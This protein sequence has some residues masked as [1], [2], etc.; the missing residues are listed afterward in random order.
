MAIEDPSEVIQDSFDAQNYGSKIKQEYIVMDTPCSKDLP[1]NCKPIP[2]DSAVD[3]TTEDG[4][5]SGDTEDPDTAEEPEN[6]EDPEA[7]D[8]DTENDEDP[9]AGDDEAQDSDVDS[10][11]FESENHGHKKQ[12]HTKC[13]NKHNQHGHCQGQGPHGPHGPH[14]HGQGRHGSHG[15][16]GSHHKNKHPWK[17][18]CVAVGNFCGN[19]LYGCKFNRTTQ[20]TCKA[21]GDFPVPIRVNTKICGGTNDVDDKCT[22]PGPGTGPV[23]G[24]ELPSEC[25]ATANFI[26]VCRGG[27]GSKPEVLSICRPGSQCQ[28]K[29]LPQG[30]ICGS[31][32][33]DCSGNNELCSDTFPDKCGLQKNSIYQ[34]SANGEPQLVKTCKGDQVCVTITDGSICTNNNC[35]CPYDGT[36]CGEVFPLTC[37]IKTTA[38]YTCTTGGDPVLVQDCY[39]NRCSASKASFAATAVFEAAAMDQCT[40]SCT[41]SGTGTVCG[42]TFPPTCNLP[43]S[44][45][46]Q[47][48]GNGQNP[49]LKTACTLGGCTVNAG[50]DACSTDPCTCPG[51]GFAPV[52]GSDLPA[53]CN[54][55]SN[56]IY[57]CPGGSGTQPE[58]LEICK[59]GT[60]CNKKPEPVGAIC[61]SATC[62][63]TG[64]NEVCSD[65]FPDNCNVVPNSI[66]QCTSSGAPQLVKTCDSTQAC[67]SVSDGSICTRTDCKCPDDGTV[68]GEV[69]PLYC[70]IKTTA[71]YTCTKGGD[72]VLL[73][74]CY[75]NRCT[76]SVASMS[77]A[78]VFE[79]MAADQCADSCKCVSA[80]KVCGSTFP[81][82]CGLLLSTL[83]TCSGN[84]ATPVAGQACGAGG[85]TV[86]AGD[87]SCDTNNCTC[88]GDGNSPVCSSLLPTS[89]N[90]QPNTIYQ[91]PGGA[92]TTPEILAVCQPGTLCQSKPPPV[93][94]VCGSSTC[95]CTGNNEVCSDTFPDN[96]NVVPNSIYQCTSSGTPQLVKTCDTTQT[97]ISVADGSIC[98]VPNCKC[99]DDGVVCGQVF[100]LSCKLKTTAL[101]TCT[102]GGDP[103]LSQDCYP[104]QCISSIATFS[105]SAVFEAELTNDQCTD[106]CLCQGTGVS[107]GS[108]FQPQCN[109]DLST[110]YT[111]S[112]QGAKPV[113]GQKCADGQCVVNAGDDSC[114]VTPSDCTCPN[115]APICGWALAAVCQ[116]IVDI[117]PN[118]IYI[119]PT[120]PG[121]TPEL[122]KI[123]LPGTTCQAKPFPVGAACG[124][125]TCDCTGSKQVCT[126]VFPNDCG[127]VPNSI[128]QCS[129]TGT[130]QLVKTCTS[131][132]TC[133]TLADGSVCVS[134]D[135]K[136]T[137]NGIVCGESFP[138]SCGL[139]STALYTCVTG[140]SPVF[141]SDCSPN[142]CSATVA[143]IT[144]AMTSSDTCV[145]SCLCSS[146]DPAVCGS[147]FPPSCGLS[148]VSLYSCAGP[149]VAPVLVNQCPTGICIVNP[150]NDAC[151]TGNAC[152]CI[153]TDNV[154]GSAFPGQCNFALGGLY[155][156]AG[157]A[158]SD[159]VLL[160]N[161]PGGVCVIQI[162]NDVCGTGPCSC[163]DGTAACGATFPLQCLTDAATLYLCPGGAGSAPIPGQVCQSGI[164][165]V[166]FGDDTCLPV[167][168][169]SAAV[170]TPTSTTSATAGQASPISTVPNSSIQQTNAPTA[171]SSGPTPTPTCVC[172]GSTK[173]CGSTFPAGCG[174]N[175]TS[176]YTCTAAGSPPTSP[177]VNCPNG[178]NTTTTPDHSC[179]Q[180]CSPQANAIISQINTITS[181]ITPLVNTS[182]LTT[183][184]FG[185]VLQV[186]NGIATDLTNNIQN[187]TALAPIAGTANATLAGVISIFL[188]VQSL[189]P[190]PANTTI[191]PAIN[192]L[193]ALTPLLQALLQCSGGAN[194]CSALQSLFTTISNT[195]IAALNAGGFTQMAATLQ[196]V[197]AVVLSTTASSSLTALNSAGGDINNL[198]YTLNS[199]A[200]YGT[201]GQPVEA[202][203]EA[204]KALLLCNGVNITI[205][206][207]K[208]AAFAA[209]VDGFLSNF[210]DFVSGILSQV[211]I[212]G[213][214]I[215]TPVLEAL[216]Q[217][218]VDLQSGSATAIGG[219]LS[220]LQA[221]IQVFGLLPNSNATTASISTYIQQNLLGIINVPPECQ[222][223]SNCYGLIKIL[224]ILGTG[225][226]NIV[227]QV[228]I[229]GPALG[230]P[231]SSAIN[232]VIS[233]LGSGSTTTIQA[234][235]DILSPIVS[236]AEAL[237]L[238]GTAAQPFRVFLD[239]VKAILDCLTKGTT[240]TGNTLGGITAIATPV[241]TGVPALTT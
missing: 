56:T 170:P 110:L 9:E 102:K 231:L 186:F 229:V 209:K 227:S 47:C 94:A 153:D 221:I 147:T 116:G 203:Y 51:L 8:A 144:S 5:N 131:S 11:D 143:A 98:V 119:C 194:D 175:A 165:V 73:K 125:T 183:A 111:C 206:A 174:L 210:I 1:A 184:A 230:G 29:P 93:G 30:A 63:C 161:C 226:G 84:G 48:S 68:C 179:N 134:N 157:G 160:Q 155:S 181:A 139:V 109:L 4:P 57:Y 36:V 24:Y 41:C 38:L 77:A 12:N 166:N 189:L 219:T 79:A 232:G 31:S 178:C 54:A 71:L 163:V 172:T 127:L 88:P 196:N 70:K 103:V 176:L 188:G 95:N 17:D 75:P 154:C 78:S 171:T 237:P 128:Y 121:S 82:S 105:A 238:V 96:C 46:Y 37:L 162:G 200:T 32:T 27:K 13:K 3:E 201:L 66:Y 122:S 233:A 126:D 117:N 193:N 40:D 123:C 100:P 99:P 216:R 145:D 33:C 142:R 199:N 85:C 146:V 52:C 182:P 104:N 67:V 7:G 148:T 129:S 65:S 120:G 21:V 234:A 97:C 141:K 60:R 50:D 222:A 138:P 83:Y 135:C 236:A 26:Y 197:T 14:G 150:G 90:A 115:N 53:V 15:H 124:G 136:C 168:S 106:P 202:A 191:Q 44:N 10:E 101:Y 45:L 72:P 55:D 89:C 59:P 64:N 211:P 130:P 173:V 158:G 241:R 156:C 87:D 42:S 20:Y 19:K 177:P 62:D 74:D 218:V 185:P 43:A 114:G 198:I 18:R 164:C 152:K 92:G 224:T 86:N 151:D 34:C 159:P 223:A 28:P 195:A 190:S 35:K 22:C 118:A 80:G 235:Y 240:N 207:N 204:A 192:A 2:Y 187:P 137:T 149:G 220:I 225:I 132:Q 167:A 208:C 39:P 180:D 213:P 69:F 113:P 91:C 107:C 6:S 133:V 49:V 61:G 212:I 169:G 214:L 239:G 108:T 58:V 215:A 23:C 112:G 16:N 217:L 76:A 205:F 25:N 81:P 228:P 140:Q